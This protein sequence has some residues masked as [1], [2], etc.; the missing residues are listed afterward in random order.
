[1]KS[2]IVVPGHIE[3]PLEG[4]QIAILLGV[5]ILLEHW[6]FE[7]PAAQ[8]LMTSS[9]RD[10]APNLYETISKQWNFMLSAAQVL[11]SP[12]RW[13]QEFIQ[14]RASIRGNLSFTSDE[15]RLAIMAL[16]ASLEEFSDHWWEFWLVAPGGL[17]M[18][19]VEPADLAKLILDLEEQSHAT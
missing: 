6:G 4:K 12:G 2:R 1:M 10:G 9:V 16:R 15:L 3:V 18:Y 19:G 14:A 5:A 8:V 11:T 17:D 7:R 13:T